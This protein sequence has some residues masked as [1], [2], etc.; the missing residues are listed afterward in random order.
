MNLEEIK[1][2]IEEIKKYESTL[3]KLGNDLWAEKTKLRDEYKS[4]TGKEI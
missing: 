4:L 1:A 2:R 3:C